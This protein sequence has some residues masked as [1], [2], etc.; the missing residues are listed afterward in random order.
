MKVSPPKSVFSS[1]FSC[2]RLNPWNGPKILCHAILH[3]LKIM[4]LPPAPRVENFLLQ[5]SKIMQTLAWET[6]QNQVF[7][8]LTFSSGTAESVLFYGSDTQALISSSYKTG[9]PFRD[10][11]FFYFTWWTHQKF[12][13]SSASLCLKLTG[14]HAG[15]SSYWLAEANCFQ[16]FG[17]S[18][19]LTLLAWIQSSWKY[20]HHRKWQISN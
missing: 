3:C 6:N 19:D 5:A 13:H 9:C 1:L 17:E 15:A 14:W 10:S 18:V 11:L 4:C 16:E 8:G 12:I 2:L 7:L 20:L